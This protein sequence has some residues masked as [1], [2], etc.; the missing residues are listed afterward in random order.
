M[1]FFCVLKWLDTKRS[2]IQNC[3]GSQSHP[4]KYHLVMTNSSPWK[5]TMLLIGKPSISIRAI[6]SHG[7]VSHNQMVFAGI[8]QFQ[9]PGFQD[10]IDDGYPLPDLHPIDMAASPKIGYTQIQWFIIFVLLWRLQFWSQ[11]AIFRDTNFL[12]YSCSWFF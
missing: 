6:I 7:Y 12:G 8:Y 5:I 9:I 3:Y 11:T 2:W 10:R 1:D 4:R